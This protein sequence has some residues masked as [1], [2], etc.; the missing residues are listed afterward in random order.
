[1]NQ[2]I[3]RRIRLVYHSRMSKMFLI[4]AFCLGCGAKS[5]TANHAPA[6]SN[7]CGVATY[8]CVTSDGCIEDGDD[9]KAQFDMHCQGMGGKASALPCDQASALGSCQSTKLMRDTTVVR[10]VVDARRRARSRE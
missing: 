4:S 2:Q 6:V 9:F 8:S 10:G 1:M 3:V 5:P 7:A